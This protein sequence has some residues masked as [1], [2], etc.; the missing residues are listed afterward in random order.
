MPPDQTKAPKY[1]FN[2]LL[3][4][5][6]FICDVS[7]RTKLDRIAFFTALHRN[8]LGSIFSCFQL[9]SGKHAV[10]VTLALFRSR[11]QGSTWHQVDFHSCGRN[12]RNRIGGAVRGA[13]Q[14]VEVGELFTNRW[15]S[16]AIIA[17]IR[18]RGLLKSWHE[19]G[20]TRIGT[21]GKSLGGMIVEIVAGVDSH[22]RF[23]ASSTA[24]DFR[25]RTRSGMRPTG[26]RWDLN[27]PYA[28]LH[29]GIR[30]NTL[31]VPP[32]PCYSAMERMIDIFVLTPG[33]DV[34]NEARTAYAFPENQ[35]GARASSRRRSS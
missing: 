30:A 23:A 26:R 21:T 28:G 4:E 31:G 16:H 9:G 17:V 25:A 27:K 32:S 6:G 3:E 15:M 24:A 22:F 19:I 7:K 5:F 29:F 18:G 12:R 33:E 34:P 20:Y 8:G 35:D 10:D 13:G 1:L 11:D 2:L 14:A